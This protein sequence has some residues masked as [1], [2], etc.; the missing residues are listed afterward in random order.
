MSEYEE[1]CR[2]EDRW[3]GRL[4]FDEVCEI[5]PD[6]SLR[7]EYAGGV[8]ISSVYVGDDW[9]VIEISMNACEA[10]DDLIEYLGITDEEIEANAERRA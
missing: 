3:L 8:Y 7:L 10:V 6:A 9:K 4:M 5:R 1:D 2:E